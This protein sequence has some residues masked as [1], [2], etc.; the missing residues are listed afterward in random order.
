M[1]NFTTDQPISRIGY[2]LDGNA[3]VTIAGNTILTGL[4]DGEH[5]ITVYATDLAGNTGASENLHFN[6]EVPKPFPT[7]LLAAS[8]L[9]VAIISAGLLVYFKKRDNSVIK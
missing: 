1:L 6:V 7:T 2:C 8:A 9:T 4:A 3:N 5:N